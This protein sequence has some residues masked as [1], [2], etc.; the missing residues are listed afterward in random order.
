MSEQKKE[1]HYST[2][3]QAELDEHD[4]GMEAEYAEAVAA[5]KRPGKQKRARQYIGCPWEFLVDI[6]R[7]P[8]KR[9][10]LVIAL[11]VYRQTKV[12]RS[13]TVTLSGPDLVEL[14]VD[15]RR[16]REAL[17]SLEAAGIVRLRRLGRGQ[18][19]EVTLLWRPASP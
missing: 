1:R 16:K 3:T 19:T 18:K 17:R 14:G 12:R 5:T 9:T 15:P 8:H 2:M 7:L 6:C 4:A 11:L 13:Q 10:T